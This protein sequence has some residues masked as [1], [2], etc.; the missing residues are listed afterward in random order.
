[1]STA[2]ATA[3][4]TTDPDAPVWQ[5][6][7][8][9]GGRGWLPGYEFSDN[10]RCWGYH[11]A[12][13]KWTTQRA[14]DRNAK[15]RARYAAKKAAEIEAR[16]AAK[17]AAREE[18]VQQHPGIT[19]ALDSLTGEFGLS[20]R[21]QFRD[22]GVLSDKQ[23]EAV[24]RIAEENRIARETAQP[25]PSGRHTISG[26]IISVREQETR[27]GTTFKM[28]V[29]AEGGFRL[30]GTVPQALFD[31]AEDSLVGLDV[32]FTATITPSDDDPLFGFFK[33]PKV[34]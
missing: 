21:E 19:E 3:E 1:M 17:E 33:R 14:L 7:W 12:K 22:Q 8:K 4:K 34:A 13:G 10:A 6:C 28:V 20:L 24:L 18:F 5:P 23:V 30:W 11:T 2:T 27:Y 15:A 25:V 9:C 16:V 32:T 29:L 31:L 26:K